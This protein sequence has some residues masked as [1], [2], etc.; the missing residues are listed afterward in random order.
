VGFSS[1][2]LLS[3]FLSSLSCGTMPENIGDPIDIRLI[4]AQTGLVGSAALEE[5]RAGVRVAIQVDGLPPGDY[6]FQFFEHPACELPDFNTAGEPFPEPA[7]MAM[8][9]NM[10]P[11]LSRSIGRL[12]VD[13]EGK[14]HAERVAPVVTLGP[15]D[16]SLLEGGGSALVILQL[17]AGGARVAC[18]VISR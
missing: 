10:S 3:I 18:G 11:A 9:Q 2:V 17:R 12:E 15:G 8:A 6:R 16:N 7:E 1:F 5:T 4:G 13:A 14:G